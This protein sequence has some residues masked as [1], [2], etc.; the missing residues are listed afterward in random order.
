MGVQFDF[1]E[2]ARGGTATADFYWNLS[3]RQ[4]PEKNAPR[5]GFTR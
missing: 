1:G 2:P 4:P 5:S 3:Q